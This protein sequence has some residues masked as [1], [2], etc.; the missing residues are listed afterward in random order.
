MD[1]PIENKGEEF[2]AL[3]QT[4]TG[5]FIL[6]PERNWSYILSDPIAPADPATMDMLCEQGLLVRNGTDETTLFGNW[7]QQY[8]HDFSTV[9]SKVLVTRKCNNRCRYCILDP[10]AMEMSPETAR[11]MDRFYIETIE[12]KSPQKVEDDYLGGEPLLNAGIILESAGR[13]FYYC[14]GRGIEYS[15]VIT[16]NGTLIRPSMISDMKEVGLT[17]IRVSL[18]GPAPVHDRLRPSKNNGK[19]YDLIMENL[20]AIS[21]LVPI[22]IE[23]QYDSGALDFLSIPDMLDDIGER[24]IAIENVAFTP[25]LPRRGEN[26][27]DSGTGD[28]RIF[29]YLMQ[30]A[31][32]RG[33]PQ[34]NEAPSNTCMADFRARFVFDADGSIIPCPSLQG[35]EMAYGHVIKGIDFVA[36]S[37]LL[38]RR[39]PDRCLNE[40]PILPICMGGCRLQALVHQKDFNGIDCHYDTY[41]FFLEEYI[42]QRA[43][44]VSCQQEEHGGASPQ[45]DEVSRCVLLDA[46]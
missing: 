20:K 7:K 10:E 1:I 6:I 8:V 9:K 36:E 27:Y 38:K 41:R 17:G 23:C 29:S 43:S 18:A 30:E 2:V 14:L 33:F 34:D 31:G 22:T 28:P 32:K 16:T 42:R 12:E 15:F 5:A 26:P 40:C 44:A 35:G 45:T 21:G 4:M 24:N 25:I 39:L 37:E 19:T 46:A 3:Y 11:A 13:R